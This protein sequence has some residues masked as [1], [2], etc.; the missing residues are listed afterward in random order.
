MLI[1]S[2]YYPGQRVFISYGNST[3]ADDDTRSGWD[4]TYK[5]EWLQ[6]GDYTVWTISECDSCQ[7]EIHTDRIDV[8]ISEA[9]ETVTVRDLKIVY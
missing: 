2:G 9:K 4:G 8:N 5:F 6:K 3:T 7:L 1:D